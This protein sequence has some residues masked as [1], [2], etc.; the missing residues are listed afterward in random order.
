MAL[1][2]GEG[3]RHTFT[4]HLPSQLSASLRDAI[5]DSKC[6]DEEKKLIQEERIRSRIF[7]GKQFR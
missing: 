4:C 1:V 7:I 2:C 5:S 3:G 6:G